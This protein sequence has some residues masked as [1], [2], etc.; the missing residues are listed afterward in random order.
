MCRNLR[1][2][3]VWGVLAKARS[4]CGV[5]FFLNFC[6]MRTRMSESVLYFLS[7]KRGF[8]ARCNR[9]ARGYTGSPVC[10]SS[11]GDWC[12]GSTTG[13]GPV[14]LG[15]NP[16]SPVWDRRPWQF[17][18]Q[19]SLSS[20]Y[21]DRE[22]RAGLRRIT[23]SPRTLRPPART[24]YMSIGVASPAPWFHFVRALAPGLISG[25]TP[26]MAALS[27]IVVQAQIHVQQFLGD[28]HDLTGMK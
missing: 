14:S 12:N 13:S 27:R 11:F 7:R 18:S 6:K 3:C 17:E 28:L 15:S 4:T 20:P 22:P 2:R 23:C 16:R 19:P 10:R 24:I 25:K 26:R 8:D 1:H 9:V 21:M 5:A